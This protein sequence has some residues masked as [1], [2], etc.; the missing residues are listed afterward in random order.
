MNYF[1]LIWP[2]LKEALDATYVSIEIAIVGAIIAGLQL[3]Y[4]KNR[5]KTLDIRNSWEKVHKAMFEFRFR[6]EM[7]NNPHPC[8]KEPGEAAI[9]AMEALHNIRGQLDRAPDS[10]LVTEIVSFL[11]DNLTADKW[12]AADFTATFDKFVREAALKAR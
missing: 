6:R 3:R 9:E 5:D 2:H 12:R 10:P 8:A 7:L 1:Q 11:D 4:A